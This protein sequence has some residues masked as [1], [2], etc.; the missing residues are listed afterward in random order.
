MLLLL[1][2]NV[3]KHFFF[4]SSGCMTTCRLNLPCLLRRN[5]TER[6]SLYLGESPCGKIPGNKS[7]KKCLGD[8]LWQKVSGKEDVGESRRRKHLVYSALGQSFWKRVCGA[9][10]GGESWDSLCW[11]DYLA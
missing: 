4:S 11:A 2:S 9:V 1:S 10:L 6:E 8:S 7:W 3:S 5:E